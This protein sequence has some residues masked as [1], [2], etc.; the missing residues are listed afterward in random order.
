VNVDTD[1]IHRFASDDPFAFDV[2]ENGTGAVA[3]TDRNGSARLAF[4]R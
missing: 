3:W 2:G 1:D 4:F